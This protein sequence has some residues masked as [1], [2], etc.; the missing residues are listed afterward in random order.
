[1]RQGRNW[2]FHR[3]ALL[4]GGH[5]GDCATGLGNIMLAYAGLKTI[6]HNWATMML[7]IV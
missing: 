4:G 3:L 2:R 1:M 6:S 7:R 5:L